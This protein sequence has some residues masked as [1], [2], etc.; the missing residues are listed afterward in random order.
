MQ[1]NSINFLIET[2]LLDSVSLSVKV[3]PVSLER[4]IHLPEC[5]NSGRQVSPTA[6]T[7]F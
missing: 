2:E 1:Q 5:A 3:E 7:V 6:G 4:R